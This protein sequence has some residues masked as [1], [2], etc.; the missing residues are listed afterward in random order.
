MLDFLGWCLV[1]ALQA[2]L[3]VVQ[4][5]LGHATAKVVVPLLTLGTVRVDRDPS[6][7]FS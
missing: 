5:L 1:Q 3:W 7:G 6:R 4:D 2:V